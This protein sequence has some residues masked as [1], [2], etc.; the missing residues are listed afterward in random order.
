MFGNT[1]SSKI[2]I[3]FIGDSF[4]QALHVSDDKTY[5]AILSQHLP[6]EVF[7]YGGGGY[8]TLQEC[9]ILEEFAHLI[10]PA[11]IVLQYTSNDF[12]N[13][14]YDLELK[15][16]INNNRM[17]RPYLDQYDRVF[18]ALPQ[19]WAG[20]RHLVNK[21]SALMYV[22]ML[23]LDGMTRNRDATVENQI[24][25]E[26]RH[27]RGFRRSVK[28]TE[29]L[30]SMFQAA[31]VNASVFA[32]GV[33]D[34]APYYEEFKRIAKRNDITFIDGIPQA[35]RQ[36]ER[37]GVVTRAADGTHWNNFG[38]RVAAEELVKYFRDRVR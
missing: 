25:A 3:F 28:V 8:G 18:Y 26:G 14:D 24:G 37:N 2:K 30:L 12:V 34:Y 5:Y 27:H 6:I 11:I 33:D 10:D 38:H 1:A 36:A 16:T 17:R 32:F 22:L 35:V 15:S 9:M 23:R 19:R 31:S 4:T 13:N 7:A 21:H 20:L 29:R